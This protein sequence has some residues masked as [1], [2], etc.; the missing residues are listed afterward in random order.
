LQP[1]A[2]GNDAGRA[3]TKRQPWGLWIVGLGL[4]AGVFLGLWFVWNAWRVE[5]LWAE[6]RAAIDARRLEA[7]ERALAALSWHRPRDP[8]VLRARVRVALQRGD[9]ETALRVL[10]QVPDSDSEVERARMTRGL[11]LME[12]FRFREAER[13]FR[14]CVDRN[15][16]LEEAR[17]QL[18]IL[19]G[20]K[21]KYHAFEQELWGHYERC[22]QPIAPLRLL[23]RGIPFLPSRITLDESHDE[24]YLLRKGLDGD[25][26]DPEI[27][28]P[29]ARY[30]L[31]RGR[32][33][34]ALEILESWLAAYPDDG[35]ARAEW[36]ACLLEQGRLDELRPWFEPPASALAPLARYWNLRGDWLQRQEKYAEAVECFAEASRIEPRD[37]DPRYR[38]GMALRALGRNDVAERALAWLQ[39]A[40]QLLVL[41][42]K[43]KNDAPDPELC[44]QAAQ[45]LTEMDRPREARAWLSVALRA[46][47]DNA[48]ALSLQNRLEPD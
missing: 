26:S 46:D 28:P 43:I 11:L 36:L 20:L 18:V 16:S 3:A 42:H 33:D 4:L 6:A 34:E 31:E 21:R 24:G 2:A 39:K 23:S 22:G 37:P 7:A 41:M 29:L 19:T 10:R 35:P 25:P 40:N 47:P 15:P 8:D 13:V 14:Q 32:A 45:L 27:R 5:T 1:S 17:I 44:A 9:T 38:M 30:L 12:A 48:S